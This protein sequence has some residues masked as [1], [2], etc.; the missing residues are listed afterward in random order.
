MGFVPGTAVPG[1][2]PG[3]AQWAP[4]RDRQGAGTVTAVKC[5]GSTFQDGLGH[6]E[7]LEGNCV[8]PE[9][10]D[11]LRSVWNTGSAGSGA[12]LSS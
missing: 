7:R 5:P 4:R 2:Y 3:L 1:G 12:A 6:L 8:I 9:V 10:P 11:S